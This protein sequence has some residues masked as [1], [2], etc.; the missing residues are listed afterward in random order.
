MK[1][2]PAGDTRLRLL[3][4][5]AA[6]GVVDAL[7]DACF[8]ISGCAIAATFGAVG[9]IREALDDG[10]PC[11][12]I[13]LSATMIDAL[14]DEGRLIGGVPTAIAVRAGEPLP[15]IGDAA[16]L[17]A[18]LL[19]AGNIF[20]PDP[21]RATA[22][23]HFAKVLRALGIYDSVAAALRPFP[24]GAIA[25][26]ALAASTEHGNIGCTQATEIRYTSG[27][28]LAGPLPPQF[29]LATVYAAAVMRDARDP[30]AARRWVEMLTG[31]ESRELRM[32]GG[33]EP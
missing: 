10:A 33:F 13:V 25:M 17:R 18:S 3:S 11:D 26:R 29:A 14:A 32:A 21:E 7:Q 19:A 27:V 8:A 9:A 23:I 6:K 2:P 5:G 16:A 4:A 24:S 1:G 28:S 12:V 20:V 30:D 15:N 22:G 31:P